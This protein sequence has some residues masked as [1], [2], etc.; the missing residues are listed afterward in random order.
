MPCTSL[1]EDKQRKANFAFCKL[2]SFEHYAS[3]VFGMAV[4]INMQQWHANFSTK[5]MGGYSLA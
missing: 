2:T 1:H 3:N 5:T 4:S